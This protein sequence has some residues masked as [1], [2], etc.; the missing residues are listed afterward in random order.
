MSTSEYED[1]EVGNIYVTIEEILEEVGKGDR[2][3][4]IT[5]GWK[6][7]VEGETYRNIFGSHG[8]DRRNHRR[9]CSLIL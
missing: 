5:E 7:F 2:N 1:D 8:L 4:I 9:Q 3:N 6:N